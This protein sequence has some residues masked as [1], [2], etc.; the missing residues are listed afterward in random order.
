MVKI[1]LS[2]IKLYQGDCLEIMKE[3]PDKSTDMV[4]CDLP[5]GVTQNKWDCVIDVDKLW[6][7]YS[8]ILK[9]KGVFNFGF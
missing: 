8:R 4:L 2:D 3:T 9:D 7:E 6:L 1:R 5:Y